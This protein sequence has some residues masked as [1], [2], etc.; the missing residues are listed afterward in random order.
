MNPNNLILITLLVLFSVLGMQ[1]C[2]TPRIS[3]QGTAGLASPRE[4]VV[5]AALSEVGTKY[6]YGADAPG[7]A[8]DCSA[9]TQYAYRA[10]GLQIPRISMA[11]R[12][13]ST[14]V[15]PAAVKPGDL[16]FFKTGRRRHHVGLMVD[17]KRFVHA[18]SSERR[19]RL[20]RLDAPYWQK[21]LIGAGTYIK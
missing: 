9:L 20:A 17:K 11:Q 21:H 4:D 13:E 12:R 5:M 19:V 16:V 14:P 6:V 8:L 2:S 15:D 3:D 18:S 7:A 1:G 10:A